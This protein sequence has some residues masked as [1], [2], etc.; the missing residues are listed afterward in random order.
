MWG[1]KVRRLRPPRPA[2]RASS[3]MPVEEVF[4]GG[5]PSPFTVDPDART[6]RNRAAAELV[7]DDTFG[8]VIVRLKKDTGK[9]SGSL[10]VSGHVRPEWGRHFRAT[11]DRIARHGLPDHP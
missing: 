8:Y 7:D 10:V 4:V 6:E 3:T 11:L 1:R 2:R 5:E 9:P